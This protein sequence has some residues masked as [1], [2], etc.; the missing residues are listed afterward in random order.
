[1]EEHV[2]ETVPPMTRSEI[3]NWCCGTDYVRHPI[4]GEGEIVAFRFDERK[5]L[6][7]INSSAVALIDMD[8]CEMIDHPNGMKLRKAS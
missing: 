7:N 6:V 2:V 8:E 3:M 5:L 4:F 1:M